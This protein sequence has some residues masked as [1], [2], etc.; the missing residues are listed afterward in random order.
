VFLLEGNGRPKKLAPKEAAK[1]LRNHIFDFTDK[2]Q[3]FFAG[4]CP[5]NKAVFDK[6]AA[7][8]CASLCLQAD[9]WE[10]PREAANAKG[11][12]EF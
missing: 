11:L 10:L 1:K 12:P 2:K 4:L 6:T 3:F 9:C 8:L 5:L 7:K